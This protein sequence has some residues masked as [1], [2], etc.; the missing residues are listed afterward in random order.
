MARAA[1]AIGVDALFVEVHP[2]PENAPCDGQC[3]MRV[4]DL[5]VLLTDLRAIADAMKQR[6]AVRA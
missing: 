6:P 4:E 1:V 3:Q 5:D 2:D